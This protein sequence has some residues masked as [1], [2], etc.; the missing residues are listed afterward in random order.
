M[1][2]KKA[3]EVLKFIKEQDPKSAGMVVIKSPPRLQ[4]KI[5]ERARV[6]I[7]GEE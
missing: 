4:E 6:L 7:R 5:K 3:K 2:E 1:V